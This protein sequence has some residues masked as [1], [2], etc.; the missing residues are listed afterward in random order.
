MSLSSSIVPHVRYAPL[1]CSLSFVEGGH[2]QVNHLKNI[3]RL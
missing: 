3:S 2:A 1:M